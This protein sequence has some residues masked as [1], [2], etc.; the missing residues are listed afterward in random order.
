MAWSSATDQFTHAA[1][2][3][4]FVHR[5]TSDAAHRKAANEVALTIAN[6]MRD[7]LNWIEPHV[8]DISSRLSY[9]TLMLGATT[10]FLFDGEPDAL[11][12]SDRLDS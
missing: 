2:I 6:L 11:S 3:K 4:L 1:T 12:A 8:Q 10:T 9:S 7:N 5:R